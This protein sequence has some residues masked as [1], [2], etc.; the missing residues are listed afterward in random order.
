MKIHSLLLPQLIIRPGDEL[1]GLWWAEIPAQSV[2]AFARR[3]LPNGGRWM[4][5]ARFDHPTSQAKGYPVYRILTGRQ[6]HGAS[7]DAREVLGF[8]PYWSW[9]DTARG[10]TEMTMRSTVDE[11]QALIREQYRDC[12]TGKV[13]LSGDVG[14]WRSV[15]LARLIQLP[16]WMHIIFVEDAETAAT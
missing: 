4:C 3:H 1:A 9:R 12:R 5:Y 15:L 10:E 11:S 14:D 7:P 8:T 2:S 13:T 6:A 16:P